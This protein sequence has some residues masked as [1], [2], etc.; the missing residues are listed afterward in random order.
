MTLMLPTEAASR[1]SNSFET[2]VNRKLYP[3]WALISTL[4]LTLKG[5]HTCSVTRRQW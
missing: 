4:W 1:R 2:L 3:T 5:S